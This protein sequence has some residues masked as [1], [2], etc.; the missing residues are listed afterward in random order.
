MIVASSSDSR[1]ADA[2]TREMPAQGTATTAAG[3]RLHRPW[4]ALVAAIELVLA[5]V[6]VWL[7]FVVW[8]HAITEITTMTGSDKEVTLTRYHGD[9]IAGAIGLGTLAAVLVLDA[10]RELMLAV[11]TKRGRKR[12]P[13]RE[14]WP[15]G[16]ELP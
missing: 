4:R 16:S 8:S 14:Q 13:D 12:N 11:R 15:S 7:A 1:S 3:A 2:A 10:I 6:A 5:A 9:V